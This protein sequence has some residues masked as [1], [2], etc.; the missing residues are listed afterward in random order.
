MNMILQNSCLEANISV[1]LVEVQDQETYV[2]LLSVV[3]VGICMN[4]VHHQ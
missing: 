3:G 1:F 2:H 4:H